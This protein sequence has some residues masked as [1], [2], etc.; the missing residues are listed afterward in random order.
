M[1]KKDPVRLSKLR[2]T[3][4]RSLKLFK[5]VGLNADF[6]AMSFDCDGG[7]N[8]LRIYLYSY[9]LWRTFYCSKAS[10][11][12]LDIF[13]FVWILYKNT[14]PCYLLDTTS[15]QY[16]TT[17]NQSF[18]MWITRWVIIWKGGY[19]LASN[20]MKFQFCLNTT[21]ARERITIK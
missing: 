18:N 16:E 19:G 21:L 6:F 10:T 2:Q 3:S 5:L 12:T 11:F 7:T 17:H 14:C 13:I 8:F 4:F 20:V 1:T 9:C 15:P